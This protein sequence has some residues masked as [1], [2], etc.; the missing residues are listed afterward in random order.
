MP[1]SGGW[2]DKETDQYYADESELVWT[3]V[4]TQ[5][6][7]DAIIDQAPVWAEALQQIKLMVTISQASVYYLV[8]TRAQALQAA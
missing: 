1:S 8:G 3:P 6:K 4:K 5:E 7:V 2:Y